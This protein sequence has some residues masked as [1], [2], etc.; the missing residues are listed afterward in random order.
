M[1]IF[2]IALCVLIMGCQYVSA[3]ET[4][5]VTCENYTNE[6]IRG[7]FVEMPGYREI[8]SGS[9][10]I[11]TYEGDWP[12]EMQGAFEYAVKI[13]EEVLPMT[14][15]I[16][17]KARLGSI[18]G[19]G[20]ILSKVSF[21]T[22]DYNG[23]C[24][25]NYSSPN[26][27]V[28]ALL[29]Q[30][31]HTGFQ[32]QFYDE[33]ED[34]SVFD[35]TDMIIEYNE[36]VVG[37]MDFSLDGSPDSDKY[38]FVTVVLRDIA[39]GLGFT[40]SFTANTTQSKLNITGKRLIPFASHIMNGLNTTD[41]YI[42]FQ[43]ATKGSVKIDLGSSLNPLYVYAPKTWINGESL[44]FLIADDNPI[45]KLLAYDFGKGYVMH[46]LSGIEWN[47]LFQRAL[48][49]QD[50][51]PSGE[52]DSGYV[53][54]KGSSEDNL[55]YKRE[56]SL[57][58]SDSRN[59]SNE[60]ADNINYENQSKYQETTNSKILI[61]SICPMA[62]YPDFPSTQF[63]MRY[64]NFSPEG[65]TSGI[66]LSVLKKDGSWDCIFIT[67]G[68]H[69]PIVLNIEDL[70]LNYDY[71]EYARGTSGG[72]RYRLTECKKVFDSNYGARYGYNTKYF[73]RD[74]VPQQAYIKYDSKTS[75]VNNTNTRGISTDDWFI[76]VNIGIANI[77]GTT[78]V[79][80]EQ[81][82][83]GEVLPFQYEVKD[84]R[85]GYFTA[86]LDREC[87]TQL[88][89]ICYNDNGYSRSN[90][91]PIKAIGYSSP[92]T[93]SLSNKGDYIVITG[94]DNFVDESD[95]SYTIQNLTTGLISL[96]NVSLSTDQV[97]ISNMPKGIYSIIMY[98]KSTQIS[99]LKF[100]K[101]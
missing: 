22:M 60:T 25:K 57:T 32:N 66:S 67:T 78:K 95:I 37:Q 38:D 16:N 87:D 91:I 100:V 77:E 42:A 23:P 11:V 74:F 43:N 30:E 14:L 10:F 7:V 36:K 31:Y 84:F 40:S 54:P 45:S 80:V 88:T 55:P 18:R 90:T 28:K 44:R 83:D 6:T 50:L 13:W 76:D 19:S 47:E 20:T 94:L 26:S 1:K 34:T 15:P 33:I 98:Q 97:D 58:I 27:M 49:W 71:S 63:C 92:R 62:I 24:T 53:H 46:D 21:E 3:R 81:L 51:K 96:Q 101:K 72:L 70:K 93:L 82:E 2:K 12:A 52:A 35:N 4:N 8:K 39:I 64:D 17:I 85:K 68:H 56:V 9:K 75:G 29:L 89:V 59:K 48:G 61:D 86:N 99:A 41:P 69:L 73:T 5:T 65:P 79:I